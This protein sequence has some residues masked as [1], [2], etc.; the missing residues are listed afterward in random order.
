MLTPDPVEVGP[1]RCGGYGVTLDKDAE[2]KFGACHL[3]GETLSVIEIERDPA[4][5]RVEKHGTSY[6]AVAFDPAF[7]P[8]L[9]GAFSGAD[10]DA[11]TM[12]AIRFIKDR[13]VTLATVKWEADDA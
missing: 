1:C 8:F 5:I 11:V 13:A 10:R 7:G 12:E 4:M 2:R 9:G 3:T 6:Q